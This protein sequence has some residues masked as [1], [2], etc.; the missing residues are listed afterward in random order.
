M[1][2]IG[3][4]RRLFGYVRYSWLLYGCYCRVMCYVLSGGEVSGVSVITFL[5]RSGFDIRGFLFIIGMR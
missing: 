2:E 1:G 3:C 5:Y 4:F